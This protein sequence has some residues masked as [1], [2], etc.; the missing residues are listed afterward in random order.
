MYCEI[1]EILSWS[2]VNVRF[3]SR[4]GHASLVEELQEDLENKP[5]LIITS[6]GGGGLA[7]GILKGILVKP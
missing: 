7:L 4:D 1:Y 2:W 6:V 3:L 5:D